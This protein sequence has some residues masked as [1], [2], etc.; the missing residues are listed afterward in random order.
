[1]TCMA[2]SRLGGAMGDAQRGL[3]EDGVACRRPASASARGRGCRRRRA[4]PGRI[5]SAPARLATPA[6]HHVVDDDDLG[7][8]GFHQQVDDMRADEAGAAG[9]QTCACREE[10]S[11]HAS[12]VGVVQ[13]VRAECLR[14]RWFSAVSM[15]LA[16]CAVRQFRDRAAR[17]AFRA[18]AP[19]R[20]GSRRRRSRGRHRQA[21]DAPARDSGCWSRCRH[22]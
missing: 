15:T 20:P 7:A 5:A 9:H 19:R 8:A 2:S 12:E 14:Q 3:V 21:A 22:R 17:K 10:C 6:A 16:T 11:R 13:A 1:M 18:P 4:R